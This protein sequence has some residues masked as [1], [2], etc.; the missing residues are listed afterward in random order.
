MAY[1]ITDNG[2][3]TMFRG[4]TVALEVE[5]SVH[6]AGN[7]SLEEQYEMQDGDRLVLTVRELPSV[8]APVLFSTTSETNR[9]LIVPSDTQDL[10]PGE[11][12]AD[13]ELRRANGAVDTVYPLLEN[14]SSRA[15][16]TTV[17]WKNFVLIGDVT[18]HD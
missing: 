13:I 6:T 18:H 16:K 1:E 17:N 9:I 11:Y 2:V 14:L 8:T 5:L 10:E 15:R 7:E 3:I 12:S 4:D